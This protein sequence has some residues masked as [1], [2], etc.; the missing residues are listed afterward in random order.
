MTFKESLRAKRKTSYCGA[1]VELQSIYME[2]FPLSGAE[3]LGLPNSA[4]NY[5]WSY[6]SRNIR[7]FTFITLKRS[8][9]QKVPSH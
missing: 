2:T 3:E 5:V 4:C 7:K 6:R 1:A 9:E 8:S